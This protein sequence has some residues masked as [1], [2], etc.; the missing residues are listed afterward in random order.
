MTTRDHEITDF[1]AGIIGAVEANSFEQFSLWQDNNANNGIKELPWIEGGMGLMET[2]GHIDGRPV[3]ISLMVNTIDGHRILF[4]YA[5]SEVVD[6]KMIEEW[7]EANM[8]A[9]ALTYDGRVNRTDAMNF[10]NIFND[11]QHRKW[12]EKERLRKERASQKTVVAIDIAP[13]A[14]EK[15]NYLMEQCGFTTKEELVDACFSLFEFAVQQAVQGKRIGSIDAC[16]NVVLVK[17]D[18][19][20][21]ASEKRHAAV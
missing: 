16:D 13:D 19:L 2:V 21:R 1:L 14:V 8:P 11:I 6:H 18:P 17:S 20:Q 9:S 3:C 5:T 12:I 15:C 7:I 4:Y 10:H